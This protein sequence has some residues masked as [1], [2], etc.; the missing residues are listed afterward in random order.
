MS[1]KNIF[2]GVERNQTEITENPYLNA[3]KQWNFIMGDMVASRQLWQFVGLMGLLIGLGGVAGMIYIGSQSKFVPYLVEVDKLGETVAVGRAD[4]AQPADE[5]II[6]AMLASFLTNA[7]TV[8]ADVALQRKYILDV[9][10][11]LGAQDPATMKM[12]E[13]LN[14]TPESTPFKRAETVLVSV[15]VKS[16]LRQTENSW[17]I[18]WVETTRTHDGALAKPPQNMKGLFNV[19]TV[20]PTKEEQL[21]RNPIGLFIKDFSWSSAI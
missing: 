2:R 1:L 14:G 15:E 16:V 9:Y 11:M 3:R 19:Y 5:R 10:S 17:Q 8:T 18:D 12:N 20:T 6:K 13:W 7:R 4:I 21:L